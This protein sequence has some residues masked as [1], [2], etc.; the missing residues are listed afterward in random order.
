MATAAVPHRGGHAEAEQPDQ[1][2]VEHGPG[3]GAQHRRIG[4]GQVRVA[5]RGAVPVA[6]Q[7]QPP[8]QH[9]AE[10]GDGAGGQRHAGDDGGLGGQRRGPARHRGQGGRIMPV[11]YSP[12]T[13]STATMATTAWPS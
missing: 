1:G 12:L 5:V 7:D 8:G 6:G 9:R 13:A 3:G 10:D 2:Q 11:L 4:Q